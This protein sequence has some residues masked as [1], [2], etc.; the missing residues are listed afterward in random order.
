MSRHD[1]VRKSPGLPKDADGPVFS[2]P[3]QAQAFA[4]VVALHERGLFTWEEWAQTLSAEVKAPDAAQ[5]GSDYVDEIRLK[6][7]LSSGACRR[8]PRF[9]FSESPLRPTNAVHVA[10]PS[11]SMIARTRGP[12]T[13]ALRRD[14]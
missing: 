8:T 3:W 9:G 14:K 6:S 5:D 7:G 10:S 1:A 2:A 13:E 4:M 12:K 11:A